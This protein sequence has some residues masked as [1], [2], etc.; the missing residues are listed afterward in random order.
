MV[1]LKEKEIVKPGFCCLGV[2]DECVLRCK[3]CEKWKPDR[4]IKDAAVPTIEDWKRFLVCL[5]DLVGKDFEIDFG[6][7]E[8]FLK[9]DLLSL[10]RYS[11]DLGFKTTVASNGYLLD[12]EMSKKIADS[13]LNSLILSLDSVSPEIH[14]FLR[15]VKGVHRNVLKAIEYVHRNCKDIHIGICSIMMEKNLDGIVDL[16]KWAHYDDRIKSIIF[17]AVMQP[18]NTPANDAWYAKEFDYLWPKDIDKA[19]SILDT[20]ISMTGK[21]KI[22][23]KAFQLEAFKAYFKNPQSFVKKTKCNLDHAVHVSS[24][25][26]IFLCFHHGI[27]GNIKNNSED[28][29][30]I[31]QSEK[32]DKVRDAIGNCK[33]N[34]HFLLNCFFEEDQIQSN[35][36]DF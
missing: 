5:R 2:I 28:I 30:E 32:A 36:N 35:C 20:L 27:V 13:G 21:Y 16:A 15:G 10:V 4:L 34:C 17:M 9:K 12:E 7:G 8:P 23:N 3:M 31:W 33:E 24:V 22:G 26:D 1:N 19:C 29:R 25:G 6:G 11:C 18:N 14:D